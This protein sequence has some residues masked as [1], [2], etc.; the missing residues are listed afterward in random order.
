MKIFSL[1]FTMAVTSIGL[2]EEPV[3]FE[4]NYSEVNLPVPVKPSDLA[5]RYTAADGEKI[6]VQ[7]DQSSV[8][9]KV[10]FYPPKSILGEGVSVSL[11]FTPYFN[12]NY[13]FQ[14]PPGVLKG[15][16]EAWDFE[17]RLITLEMDFSGCDRLV[18]L[19]E[20]SNRNPMGWLEAHSA[21][22]SIV[23]PFGI[24][25]DLTAAIRTLSPPEGEYAITIDIFHQE[26]HRDIRRFQY[27]LKAELSGGE[28]GS[29]H[30]TVSTE[31][32]SE[33]HE[34][35]LRTRMREMEKLRKGNSK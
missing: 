34:A 24:Q 16:T 33:M 3:S 31:D 8:R 19:I 15:E 11:A 18:D 1:A 20:N 23:I 2:G 17:F 29:F 14:M 25:D 13:Y 30:F 22:H 10:L 5:L 9:G 6:I 28:D 12:A 35:D 27:S 26:T 7:P 4:L 21:A 32:F